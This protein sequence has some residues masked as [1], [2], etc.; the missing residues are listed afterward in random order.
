MKNKDLK[1]RIIEISYKYKKTHIGSCLTALDII[2]EIYN[3][4]RKGEKFILSE[5]HA[6][7]ALYCVLEKHERR[8][9]EYLLKKHGIH[10]GRDEKNGIWCTTGSLGQGLPIALG[11]AMANKTKNVYCMISDGEAAEGSIWEALR[12]K[13]DNNLDNLKVY[14]NLNGYGA[15]GKINSM[16]LI[17]RLKAFCPDIIIKRTDVQQL[18]FLKGQDAHYYIMTNQDYEKAL[19]LLK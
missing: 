4:K 13:T 8:N 2:E 3:L 12:I 14:V 10:A 17:K 7:I 6:A 1:K 9:P 18:P 11:M 16:E 5:G 15:Y 19:E